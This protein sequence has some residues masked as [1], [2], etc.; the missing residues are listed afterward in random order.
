MNDT[1]TKIDLIKENMQKISLFF[2][3]LTDENLQ[4]IYNLNLD[5]H[6]DFIEFNKR[7][8]NFLKISSKKFLK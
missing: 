6:N 2:D 4:L 7:L 8:N 1:H 5:D 3:N